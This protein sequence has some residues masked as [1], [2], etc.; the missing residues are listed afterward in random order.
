MKHQSVQH[1][2]ISCDF[3]LL[4]SLLITITGKARG[5]HHENW[6]LP[7]RQQGALL[8]HCRV[9][10]LYTIYDDIE[11][12]MHSCFQPVLCLHLSYKVK[13]LLQSIPMV[14]LKRLALLLRPS[15]CTAISPSKS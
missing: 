12:M 5:Y 13:C 2:L 14:T 3:F 9:I 6:Y 4:D 7:C 1:D 11:H 10:L 8:K 15:T